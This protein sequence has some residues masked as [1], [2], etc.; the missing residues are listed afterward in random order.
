MLILLRPILRMIVCVAT[1]ARF[2]LRLW[3]R[4]FWFWP[5]ALLGREP[6]GLRA[7][8][9]RRRQH[10]PTIRG[11]NLSFVCYSNVTNRVYCQQTCGTPAVTSLRH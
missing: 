7:L 4:L 5:Q 1:P 6:S 11:S 10:R 2:R 8:C 9:K 3:L